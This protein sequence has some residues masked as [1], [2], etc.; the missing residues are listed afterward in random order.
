[1]IHVASPFKLSGSEEFFFKPAIDGTN[2][3]LE[4]C[5]QLDVKKLVV[6]SSVT[7]IRSF[8]SDS[9]VFDET[10]W[11]KPEE[12]NK[13]NYSLSKYMAE[14]AV[15]EFHDSMPYNSEMEIMVVNPGVLVGKLICRF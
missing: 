5:Y 11:A 4:H 13:N 2:S 12:L 1:M 10:D 6:T 9:K 14:K 7:A 8:G 3:V 15:W